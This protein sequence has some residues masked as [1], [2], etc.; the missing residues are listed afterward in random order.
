M[1]V[2]M[3]D[4]H[5]HDFVSNILKIRDDHMTPG[6]I[7]PITEINNIVVYHFRSLLELSLDGKPRTLDNPEFVHHAYW[8]AIYQTMHALR[9]SDMT[10]PIPSGDMFQIDEED[11]M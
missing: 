6:A 11:D 7:E 10:T 2:N 3:T 9:S 8:Y 5:M 4:Q 1:H